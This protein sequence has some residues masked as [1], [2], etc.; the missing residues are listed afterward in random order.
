MG[1]GYDGSRLERKLIDYLG[2]DVG[3]DNGILMK[4]A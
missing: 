3:A 2:D 4:L 1:S